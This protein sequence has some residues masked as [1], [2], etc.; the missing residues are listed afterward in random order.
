MLLLREGMVGGGEGGSAEEKAIVCHGEWRV[1]LIG[2]ARL[3]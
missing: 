3:T 1:M 2:Y